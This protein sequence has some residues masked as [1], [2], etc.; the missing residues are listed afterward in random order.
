MRVKRDN[1]L[2]YLCGAYRHM[3]DRSVLEPVPEGVRETSFEA[4]I[5]ETVEAVYKNEHIEI[6][7]AK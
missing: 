2:A 5:R 7:E 6:E 3:T 1:F 4:G